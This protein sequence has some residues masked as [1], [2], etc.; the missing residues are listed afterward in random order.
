MLPKQ[1]YQL[2]PSSQH[3]PVGAWGC[4]YSNFLSA[5]FREASGVCIYVHMCVYVYSGMCLCVFI[6]IHTH[7]NTQNND[8]ELRRFCPGTA[9][10]LDLHPG[11]ALGYTRVGR[12]VPQ[13]VMN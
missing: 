10:M 9:G 8:F 12:P 5:H 6:H 2:E 7:T 11:P 4:S 13:P 1:S 3:S